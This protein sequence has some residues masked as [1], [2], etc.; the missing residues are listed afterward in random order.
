M[1][2]GS[3]QCDWIWV[4]YGNKMG[5]ILIRSFG[6]PQIDLFARLLFRVN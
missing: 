6:G 2:V 5:V 4:Y 3:E 1:A